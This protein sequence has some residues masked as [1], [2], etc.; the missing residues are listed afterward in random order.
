MAKEEIVTLTKALKLSPQ[1]RAAAGQL[2][3]A[4]EIALNQLKQE[5]KD[6]SAGAR[7]EIAAKAAEVRRLAEEVDSGQGERAVQCRVIYDVEHQ[8]VYIKHAATGEVLETRTMTDA[9]SEIA[10]QETIPGLQ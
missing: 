3:A 9:E 8:A 10:R 6:A 7:K 2:L 5:F 1:E 4:E